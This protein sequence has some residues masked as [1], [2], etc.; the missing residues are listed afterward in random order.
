MFRKSKLPNKSMFLSNR[1]TLQELS[2]RLLILLD[3]TWTNPTLRY[4]QILLRLNK[5]N[6]ESLIESSDIKIKAKS[7]LS[8]IS[9]NLYKSSTLSRLPRTNLP[10][11][12]LSKEETLF[13][14]SLLMN[15]E[16]ESKSE[17]IVPDT[18]QPILLKKSTLTFPMSKE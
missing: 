2:T 14:N 4:T 12:N 7:Q 17:D 13:L 6:Q 15:K 10:K 11:T 18:N 5:T 3:N 9:T 1:L 16:E 8:S